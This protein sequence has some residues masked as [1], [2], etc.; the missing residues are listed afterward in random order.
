MNSITVQHEDAVVETANCLLAECRHSIE[1]HSR[2]LAQWRQLPR[3]RKIFTPPPQPPDISD[4]LSR[5]GQH[6]PDVA[7]E[8]QRGISEL[9]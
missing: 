1:S 5:A 9:L 6:G 8:L 7:E 2:Q 4:V 3:L